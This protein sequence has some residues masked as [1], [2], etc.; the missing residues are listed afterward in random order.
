MA[1]HLKHIG[2]IADGNRRWAKEHGLSSLDGH[3]QGS[4]VVE[5]IIEELMPSGI[6]YLSF[7]V[8]STE[9]WNRPPE[10]VTCLM[11]LVA[12][13]IK[14]LTKK[15]Q[16]NNLRI[17]IIGR[18]EKVDPKL[19][20][21][22]MESEKLTADNTG[23]TLC[24]CFNYGGQWEIADAAKK[25]TAAGETDWTPENFRKYLYHPE[26]PDIDLVVRT[27]G[28]QRLSG[29]QLWRAAYAELLFLNKH[30]PALEKSD[31]RAI[32]D[33]YNSRERRFGK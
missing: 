13:E 29:F 25:A 28:E 26:V 32:I 31:V 20:Q 4:K 24:F 17:A 8:F 22:M 18:P 5:M 33:E 2:F 19:W 1:D 9:N 10:E 7:Y 14:R 15:A 27:S 11:N 6:E 3:K 12:S 21:E 30:F 23:M 16:K